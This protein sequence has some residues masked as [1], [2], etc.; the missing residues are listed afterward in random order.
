MPTEDAISLVVR[1]Y[2]LY[3]IEKKELLPPVSKTD[4]IPPSPATLYLF[5]LLADNQ[6]LT[7][8]EMDIIVGYIEVRR[9]RLIEL[10]GGIPRKK[11]IAMQGNVFLLIIIN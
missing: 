10:E 3:C 11:K 6:F 5:N 7:V 2:E 4:F 1:N 8:E 9:D